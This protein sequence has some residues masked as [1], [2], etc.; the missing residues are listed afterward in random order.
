MFKS[1][2]IAAASLL[3]WTPGCAAVLYQSLP[4]VILEASAGFEAGGDEYFLLRLRIYYEAK[5]LAAFPDGGIPRTALERVYLAKWAGAVVK[6]EAGVPV[7]PAYSGVYFK[8]SRIRPEKHGLLIGLRWQDKKAGTKDQ[9]CFF[10]APAENKMSAAADPGGEW[11]KETRSLNETNKPLRDFSDFDAAGLPNPLD[12]APGAGKP[13]ELAAIISKGLGDRRLRA[14]AARRLAAAGERDRLRAAIAG[15]E[16][17]AASRK[18]Y[19]WSEEKVLLEKIL[20]RA[21]K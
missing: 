5:G 12:Y 15:L 19:F 14:A 1:A 6:A 11:P 21:D 7:P 17:I 9:Q 18:L 20:A 10:F 13:E 16:K 3:A 8:S 4:S 2:F